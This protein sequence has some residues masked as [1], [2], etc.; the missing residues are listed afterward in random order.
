MKKKIYSN[1]TYPQAVASNYMSTVVPDFVP[2]GIFHI[3][4]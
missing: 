1:L 3:L 2:G 4:E